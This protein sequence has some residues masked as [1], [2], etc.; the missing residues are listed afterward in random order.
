MILA[1]KKAQEEGLG[2][3][4][5]GDRLTYIGQSSC[6]TCTILVLLYFLFLKTRQNGRKHGEISHAL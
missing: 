5:S 2:E 3:R 6:Q 4:K 1:S